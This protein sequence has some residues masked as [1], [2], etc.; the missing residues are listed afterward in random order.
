MED[1]RTTLKTALANIASGDE[2]AMGI[3][4][5]QTNRVLFGSILQIVRSRG[6][7]E[8]ILQDVYM[9][10]WRR[11]STYRPDK[12]KPITWLCAIARNSAIDVVRR[13]GRMTEIGDDV[14][15]NFADDAQLADDWLCDMEDHEALR[16]CIETLRDDHRKSIRLAY[17]EGYTYSELANHI[18]VPIGTVKSWI[19]RGLTGLKGCLGG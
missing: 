6:R 5:D 14:L 11:A 17:F 19:S 9:K 18:G 4:Y 3:L 10:I 2:A 16:E 15:E 8:D 13:E 7:A 1:R 12:G